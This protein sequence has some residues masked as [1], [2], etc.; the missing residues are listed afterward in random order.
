MTTTRVSFLSLLVYVTREM[1]VVKERIA[2]RS[3]FVSSRDTITTG[4]VIATL[5][6][7]N[8]VLLS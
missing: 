2:K 3:W 1:S 4:A 8:E 5:V 7:K 6:L